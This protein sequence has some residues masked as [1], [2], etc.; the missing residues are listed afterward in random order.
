MEQECPD[1]VRQGRQ[2]PWLDCSPD[3]TG[4]DMSNK[5]FVNSH[6]LKC[7]QVFLCPS[8]YKTFISHQLQT[9]LPCSAEAQ[10]RV[11]EQSGTRIE[12]A[13]QMHLPSCGSFLY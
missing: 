12:L 5:T 1:P 3:G 2:K 7:A 6:I 9:F 11:S 4:L 13:L 8:L 10:E